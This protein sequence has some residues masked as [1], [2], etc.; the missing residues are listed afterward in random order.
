[1]KRNIL[2]TLFLYL[3]TPFLCAQKQTYN[4]AFGDNVGLT[5]Q[6]DKI[7]SFQGK[8]VNGN[9]DKMLE[10]MP[11]A[12]K[13]SIS[14]LEGVFSISDKDGN[15]LFYSNGVII[16]NGAGN[17]IYSKLGGGDS[18]AQSGIVV[19][20]PGDEKKYIC[21]GIDQQWANKMN[22][23]VVQADSPSDV[24]VLNQAVRFSGYSGTLSESVSSVVHSNG[25]DWWIVAPGAGSTGPVYLNAWLVTPQGVQSSAPAKITPAGL[26]FEN[27]RNGTMGYFKFTPDGKHFVWCTAL[28][29]KIVYGD[30]NNSTGAFSNIRYLSKAGYG[31]EFSAN[32]EYVY[33]VSPQVISAQESTLDY[34][35]YIYNLKELLRGGTTPVKYLKAPFNPVDNG[36]YAIQMDPQGHLWI[37]AAGQP[38]TYI[39]FVDNPDE[40]NNLRI[41]R[42][43]DFFLKGTFARIGLPSFSATF[44]SLIGEKVFCVN[45]N[46][47]FSFKIIQK[48]EEKT[49][50]YT[51]WN[52][53][54]H[55][56]SEVVPWVNDEAQ[57]RSHVYKHPGNYTIT[58]GA[59]DKDNKQ[60]GRY[61][62]L[63]VRVSPCMVPVNP[64]IHNINY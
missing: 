36:P 24:K 38:S 40:P 41:Y 44:F 5:W 52:W 12:F 53:G 30:F 55:T 33:V 37:T 62:E 1:M 56:E 26:N 13:T 7:R 64:N 54:D 48:I 47:E 28:E 20:Y 21:I 15:L 3:T 49:I 16:W 19:P 51:R 25:I 63:E 34:G 58:V 35:L 45:T 46:N 23:V 57:T 9:P 60:V 6:Q 17:L 4:W 14:N 43:D 59:F 31:V 39:Y 50:A 32:Q 8:G 10:N 2:I 42:L 27:G 29:K 22:C 18:S 61:H 11:G